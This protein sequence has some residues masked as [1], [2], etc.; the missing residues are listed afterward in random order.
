[1]LKSLKT[2]I[3]I[4][5]VVLILFNIMGFYGLLVGL[6]FKAKHDISRRLDADQYRSE[7]TM[8]LRV[9]LAIPYYSGS[10]D[11]ER[12]DGEIE[13]QGEFYRLV[14]QRIVHDTL[15]IICIKDPKSKHIKQALADYVKTFTDKPISKSSKGKGQITFAKD[16]LPV[17][18]SLS[19]G[20]DGWNRAVNW[21]STSDFY[22]NRS[23]PII[24]PP[25]KC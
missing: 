25:P 2:A 18:F 12:V 10:E 1:V 11:F 15:F 20:S 7:E 8:T 9:P 14:K 13:H 4:F 6:R 16:Y 17:L 19:D 5:L 3:S 22:Q 24:G 21:L 23:I